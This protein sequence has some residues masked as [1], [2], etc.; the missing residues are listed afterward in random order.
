MKRTLVLAGALGAA[1]AGTAAADSFGGVAGNEKSYVI[2]R[3]R[4]CQP[5]AVTAGAARGVPACATAS[6]TE[7][8]SLSLK[9]PS[10][11]RGG[12]AEVRAA[13]RG[14]TITVTRKTGEVVVAWDAPDPV[15][16]VVDVWR[17]TYGRLL[18]VE[19]TVRRAGREVHE[20][21]GFDVGVGGKAPTTTPEV[22]P[23]VGGPPP[24]AA[25]GAPPPADPAL[26]R[27]VTAARKARGKAALTAWTKVLGLDADH[28]EARYRIAVAQA[29]LK[30]PGEAVAALEQLAASSRGDALE[31]LVEARF[32]KAFARLVG[33]ARFRAAVRIDAAA[34]TPYERLMGLGGQWEQSLVPCD[35]PEIKVTLRRDRTFRL[36]L[37]STCEGMRERF[38]MKGTWQ[39]R[40]EA[41]ELL[42]ARPGGGSDSAPCMLGRDRDEDTLT[43]M[44]D[45]DLRFEGRPARR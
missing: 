5:L 16:A 9:T 4:V 36:D 21:V 22:T 2:G 44:I 41:V 8:A 42:V 7:L 43:C 27:A 12:A 14:R 45:A 6:T 32:D 39:Q 15:A 29:G 1:T 17:S 35:R 19:Y 24:T 25:G 23:P 38:T 33:D 31:W 20:V 37:R 10:P 3:E 26:T 34:A 18:I 11:E 28:A 40:D 30:K 13:A